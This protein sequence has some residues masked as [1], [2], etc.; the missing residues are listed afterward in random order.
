MP[1]AE[2]PHPP[3]NS[4]G[5]QNKG[6]IRIATQKNIKTNGLANLTAR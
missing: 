6:L 5:Y 4:E 1:A 2:V 3:G